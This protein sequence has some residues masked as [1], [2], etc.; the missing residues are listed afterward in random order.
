LRDGTTGQALAELEAPNSGM[1]GGLAFNSDGTQLFACESVDAVRVW[2]LGA[3][4]RQLAEMGLDWEQPPS[5]VASSPV[6]NSASV[7][8][9]PAPPV[10]SPRH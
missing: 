8:A 4:R 1:I 10:A 9:Q 3:I 6:T 2:D 5:H 7:A